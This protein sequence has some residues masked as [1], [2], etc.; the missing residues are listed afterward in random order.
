[1]DWIELAVD[2]DRWWAVVNMILGLQAPK[3]AGNFLIS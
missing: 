1:V 2:M 3:N